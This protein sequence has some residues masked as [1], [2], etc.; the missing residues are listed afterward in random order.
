MKKLGWLLLVLSFPIMGQDVVINPPLS[1]EPEAGR[2]MSESAADT[3]VTTEPKTKSESKKERKKDKEKVE[4]KKEEIKKEDA[5]KEDAKKEELK[6]DQLKKE[7]DYDYA[8]DSDKPTHKDQKNHEYVKIVEIETNNSSLEKYIQFSYGSL[9]SKW[10]KIDSTLSNGSNTTEFKL[11]ADMSE[12]NQFGFSIEMINQKNGEVAPANLRALEY[13]LFMEHHHALFTNRLDW[14]AGFGLSVGDF[15]VTTKT[16]VNGQDTYTKIKSGT[17]L[18]FI[19]NTGFRFY[20]VG[21]NSLDITVEYH[22]YFAKPQR[23]I[24]GFALAPRFSFVF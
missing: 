14:L 4:I 17:I 24:G 1:I 12:H 5:K 18:G 16:V 19:P 7:V 21:R 20:L 6:K 23:Y 22:Y 8:T 10:N 2:I 9:A 15:N 13:K 11:V 3:P